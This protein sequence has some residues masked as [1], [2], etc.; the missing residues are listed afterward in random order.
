MTV[1]LVGRWSNGINS[2]CALVMNGAQAFVGD[3]PFCV[4]KRAAMAH[5]PGQLVSLADDREMKRR[6]RVQ[7]SMN[8]DIVPVSNRSSIRLRS[9]LGKCRPIVRK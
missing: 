9:I 2:S 8:A 7:L 1:S 4:W 5:I 3:S 6:V